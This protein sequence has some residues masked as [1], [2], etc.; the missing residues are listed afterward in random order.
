MKIKNVGLVVTLFLFLLIGGTLQ[1]VHA[2][3]DRKGEREGTVVESFENGVPEGWIIYNVDGD[4]KQWTPKNIGSAKGL[5]AHSGEWAMSVL[6]NSA[7]NDDW[8]ITSQVEPTDDNH[9]FSF[10]AASNH[11]TY[12][13]SFEVRLATAGVNVDDF[14]VRL[15]SVVDMPFEW[16]HYSYDLSDYIGQT[17]RIAIRNISKD[18]MEMLVDDVEFPPHYAEND[19]AVSGFNAPAIAAPDQSSIFTV[20]V[21]NK[22]TL[23]QDNYTVSLM[24]GAEEVAVVA[25]ESIAV[26]ETK[27]AQ[28][29]WVPDGAGD[30]ELHA[31][32]NL[33]NDENLINNSTGTAIVR[34]LFQGCELVV[35]GEGTIQT[36][37]LP[38]S[39]AIQSSFSQTIYLE[40]EIE[41][42]GLITNLIYAY[43]FP[44]AEQ[45]RRAQIWLGTTDKVDLTDGWI[46]LEDLTLVYD[47]TLDYA[48]GAHNQI[49]NLQT[50]FEYEDGN[51]VV[52]YYNPQATINYN[53][54]LFSADNKETTPNR[55]LCAKGDWM[56]TV[57]P[58]NPPASVPGSIVPNLNLVV[59]TS[60]ITSLNG[61]VR[62]TLGEAA[63][64][65]LVSI[66]GTNFQSVTDATGAYSFPLLGVS[67]YTFELKRFGYSDLEA[68]L[69]LTP[70]PNIHDF[71]LTERPYIQVS[72]KVIAND[73]LQGVEGATVELEGYGAYQTD[74]DAEGNFV[75]ARV[76]C[77]NT[78]NLSVSATG[79]NDYAASE[80]IVVTDEPVILEDIVITET[81]F[82]V[83]HVD[84]IL[85]SDTTVNLSWEMATEKNK[86]NRGVERYV[87]YRYL[88]DNQWQQDLWVELADD[89][90]EMTYYDADFKNID[91]GIYRYSI[92]TIYTGNVEAWGP[93]SE[94]VEKDMKWGIP[95]TLTD[96][97]GNP[98]P[99]ARVYLESKYMNWATS[100]TR[101]YKC[102]TGDD[103]SGIIDTV[104]LETYHVYI[105]AEGY[106]PIR[107]VNIPITP[108]TELEYTLEKL[109]YT[110][111]NVTADV[112][113]TKDVTAN[114][115]WDAP[116]GSVPRDFRYDDGV[117]V[118]QLGI[119]QASD[120][121]MLGSS[122]RHDALVEEVS[123]MLTSEDHHED[124]ILFVFETDDD[125][126]PDVTKLLH[127]SK[128]VPNVDDQWNTYTLPEPVRAQNGFFVGVAAPTSQLFLGMDD[129]YGDGYD[130]EY[131]T[132]YGITDYTDPD[133]TIVIVGGWKNS[134]NFTIRAHGKD[135]GALDKYEGSFRSE[136]LN[137]HHDQHAMPE[138][139]ISSDLDHAFNT[140]VRVNDL[141][142]IS[143]WERGTY[144]LFNLEKGTEEDESTWT[145][146]Q[147][148]IGTLNYADPGYSNLA[149]GMYRYAVKA[150]YGDTTSMAIFSNV[151]YKDMS[152]PLTIH[153][154]TNE[155]G[156]NNV[157]GTK[158]ILTNNDGDG[159]HVYTVVAHDTTFVIENVWK[160]IYSISAKQAGF[161]LYTLDNVDL[162]APA[163]T[164]DIELTEMLIKPYNLAVNVTN[165]GQAILSWNNPGYSLDD[166]F[167]DYDDFVIEFNPWTN[168]DKD[169]LFTYSVSGL[170]Y[171]NSM[172]KK[173]F[174]I[175][176][177][178]ATVPAWE[179]PL[180][181][182]R[183]GSKYAVCFAAT[184][185]NG[186]KVNNDYLISPQFKVSE[187]TQ[188]SFYAKSI[189]DDYGFE[190]F[191]VEV[192]TTGVN[193]EDFTKISAGEY[194]EAPIDWANFQFDLADY[195]GEDVYVAIHC[196]SSDQFMFM[197]DDFKVGDGG[198]SKNSKSVDKHIVYLDGT[199]VAETADLNYTFTE[200]TQG[201]EYTASVKTIYT[202]GESEM[203]EITFTCDFTNHA[204]EFTSQ[205]IYESAVG[206][207]YQYN[208]TASDSD[209]DDLT[210][211]SG[212]LPAWLTFTDNGDGTA[213]L[214][215]T[216][217]VAEAVQI[218]LK[219]SDGMTEATQTFIIDIT[220]GLDVCSMNRINVYP[221]PVKDQLVIENA[222]HAS[223]ALMDIR[224]AILYQTEVNDQHLN[225]DMANYSR[226]IYF[227]RIE[228][229]DKIKMVKL[230]C[231]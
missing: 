67:Q 13:E 192:S 200:L 167:E 45:A 102:V 5:N 111:N 134:K 15:D 88:A 146:I 166:G 47:S 90:T 91:H 211:S 161:E 52:L 42:T 9:T 217:D 49:I 80:P 46:P 205:P 150:E 178:S 223:I 28:L 93:Y 212:D 70:E 24:R 163:N 76:Y 179:E 209:G 170:E 26:G 201:V 173:S 215:G 6:F 226:G 229:S 98:I 75:L 221:N 38:V 87:V 133:A 37:S 126:V 123:W 86:G 54:G 154:T 128:V 138:M 188:F 65:V 214:S 85:N 61:T 51:L 202:S 164:L 219:V 60:G 10:Y 30:M 143:S 176:N 64:N 136:Q 121:A 203:S 89:V 196:I 185:D 187:H 48:V 56:T 71:T 171:A 182:A 73:D 127:K 220:V 135:Y 53:Y 14:T 33:T 129:G 137:K 186:E 68:E 189:I 130:F 228:F 78:Y 177:P 95:V 114:I 66:K 97:E 157:D 79:Y 165:Q 191:T 4:I 16:N 22:G 140:E 152:A 172:E 8:L 194:L 100:E 190:Q 160:G 174:M 153:L 120:K 72:G 142:K 36:D 81:P 106:N 216:P 82:G 119:N 156:E 115:G 207:L 104:H 29:D 1:S 116:D 141:P 206:Q 218:E 55:T 17:L 180:A 3:P 139:F 169:G 198:I 145:L 50:P 168:I 35:T 34:V 162:N 227:L 41:S 149:M 197:V 31:V 18:E 12:L 224:G 230:V 7:G 195:I 63:E 27:T 184:N 112:T 131:G 25:G 40:S 151:L 118:S 92:K 158:I 124:V 144:Q 225:I 77:D 39:M 23:S 213:L 132:E 183:T 101:K 109:Y 159:E 105:W 117:V 19:L 148:G 44:K 59:M 32:V 113:E 222:R 110:P 103:G 181:Q 122:Y 21:M 108:E 62:N 208:I 96:N 94:D 199:Q 193:P 20:D 84:A 74:T 204:P 210:I 125:G 69:T 175:F 107:E 147:D 99:Q 11:S 57:D 155:A 43:D 83:D 2:T 58:A 231:D